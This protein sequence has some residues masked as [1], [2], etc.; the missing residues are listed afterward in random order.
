MNEALQE[1][2][3]AHRVHILDKQR[4]PGA[5][6]KSWAALHTGR[7]RQSSMVILM[8]LPHT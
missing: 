3:C 7:Q 1:E 4:R 2:C 5:M 6:K 8:L